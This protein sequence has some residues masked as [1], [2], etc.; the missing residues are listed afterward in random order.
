MRRNHRTYGAWFV[1]L[2][3]VGWSAG[4]DAQRSRT[5]PSTSDTAKKASQPETPLIIGAPSSVQLPRRWL[6]FRRG[7][8]AWTCTRVLV[9]VLNVKTAAATLSTSGLGNA[10]LT[11]DTTGDCHAPADQ[12][13]PMLRLDSTAKSPQQVQLLIPIKAFPPSPLSSEGQ[14]QLTVPGTSP[15]V[16]KLRLE[17]SPKPTM[18]TVSGWLLGIIIPGAIGGSLAFLSTVAKG[19]WEAR[20]KFDEYLWASRGKLDG[21]FITMLSNA[22]NVDSEW[23]KDLLLDLEGKSLLDSLPTKKA[24]Q[25]RAALQNDNRAEAGRLLAQSFKHY[26]RYILRSKP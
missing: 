9:V 8:D 14:I 16:V 20:R 10:R 15:S 12:G 3:L 17:E 23:C 4:A 11:F 6:G 21:V 13:A 26:R 22:S 5:A 24:L 7:N 2:A 18:V 1:A 25:I 19:S